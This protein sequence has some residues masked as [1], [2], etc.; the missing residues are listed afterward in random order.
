MNVE[1]TESIAGASVD[2]S[3]EVVLTV[4][5]CSTNRALVWLVPRVLCAVMATQISSFWSAVSTAE[6]L[7]AEVLH[8]IVLASDMTTMIGLA[9]LSWN[10]R[11]MPRTSHS[12]RPSAGGHI[13]GMGLSL[14]QEGEKAFQ[15]RLCRHA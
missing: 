7:A 3:I 13:L 5:T 6:F 4:V 15:G 8:R 12:S 10:C 9:M 14:P 1:V 11:K 2:M